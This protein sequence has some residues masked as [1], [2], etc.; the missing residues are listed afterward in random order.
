MSSREQE[1]KETRRYLMRPLGENMVRIVPYQEDDP[2]EIWRAAI[3]EHNDDRVDFLNLCSAFREMAFD[4]GKGEV[5][6]MLASVMYKLAYRRHGHFIKESDWLAK[7]TGGILS[8]SKMAFVQRAYTWAHIGCSTLCVWDEQ[9]QENVCMRSLDWQ[10]A[11]ALGKATRIFDFRGQS[12]KPSDRFTAVGVVGMLG[13]LTGMKKG[14]SVAINY[15]PWYKRS[16][17]KDMDPTFSLRKL[18]QNPSIDCF[19]KA[20]GAV[21]SWEV[22]SPAFITL[23]GKEKDQACVVEIGKSDKKYTRFSQNGVLVQTNNFDPEGDF[24]YVERKMKDHKRQK[25]HP[26]DEEGEEIIKDEKSD[27]WYCGKLIP[28]SAIRRKILEETVINFS[29]TSLELEVLLIEAYERPPVWNWE[30]AY[31]ALMRPGSDSMRVF[32]RQVK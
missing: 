20:L 5:A 13:L 27:A 1:C 15:A 21:E 11:P 28:T 17:D 19:D 32:A 16:L 26:V 25:D 2:A 31:W 10:G 18:L 3:L 8:R 22:S 6:E 7:Q 24:K 4:S 12:D 9:G 23:C 29:G 14:F 30:T